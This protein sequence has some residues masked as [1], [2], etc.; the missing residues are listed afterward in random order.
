MEKRV[1]AR[2]PPPALDSSGLP[3]RLFLL[4]ESVPL[5]TFRDEWGYEI[6]RERAARRVVSLEGQVS[7]FGK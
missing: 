6:L 4:S 7:L 5:G 1:K 3:V 2:N